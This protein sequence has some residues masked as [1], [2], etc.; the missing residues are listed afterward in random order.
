MKT[1]IV[2]LL[3]SAS[4]ISFFACRKPAIDPSA[5][6][7]VLNQAKLYADYHDVLPPAFC[8][9]TLAWNNKVI[10]LGR[11]LFYDKK[12]S[13]NNAI[14]CASCHHQVNAFADNVRFSNGFENKKTGRNTP[15]MTN[16]ALCY[17]FFWDNR[18]T[19]LESMVLRPIQ[20]HVEMGLIS[21]DMIADKL[22]HIDYYPALFA[23]AFGTAD[24]T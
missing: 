1:K 22:A 2:F 13:L 10:K 17:D 4:V 7:Q 19:Q 5:H 24:I 20:S 6:V 9:N 23:N 18:E 16:E 12:L 11:V 21:E 14:S 15:A 8:F 3:T